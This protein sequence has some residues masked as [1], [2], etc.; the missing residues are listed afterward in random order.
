[1]VKKVVYIQQSFTVVIVMLWW[2]RAWFHFST[3]AKEVVD[4]IENG[5]EI[6]VDN[7]NFPE[8]LEACFKF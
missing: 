7:D 5:A 2:R 1:M 3:A 8:Y 4:L 6:D